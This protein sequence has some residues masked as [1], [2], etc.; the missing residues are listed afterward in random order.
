MARV[1]KSVGKGWRRDGHRNQTP[2]F[3]LPLS[4]L[5]STSTSCVFLGGLHAAPLLRP[6]AIDLYFCLFYPTQQAA[7]GRCGE[8]WMLR[9]F[10][11]QSCRRCA[12][13]LGGAVAAPALSALTGVGT[14]AVT[15]A[16]ELAPSAAAATPPAAAPADGASAPAANSTTPGSSALAAKESAAAS[17]AANSTAASP[18]AVG[19]ESLQQ[20]MVDPLFEA[21]ASFAPANDSGGCGVGPG[22]C[23]TDV[24]NFLW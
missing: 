8:A 14:L 7:W 6:V 16:D 17:P 21:L 12:C 13:P 10:C 3:T 23:R 1:C 11:Q 22:G 15:A 24:L 4:A 2:A 9:L 19:S 20:Q 5:W 18:S